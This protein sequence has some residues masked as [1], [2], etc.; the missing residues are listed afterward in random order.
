PYATLFRSPAGSRDLF[1]IS[2]HS[3]IPSDATVT[4]RPSS[5]ALSPKIG[6]A[7]TTTG[8]ANR[9]RETTFV[10]SPPMQLRK[11]GS[12]ST[13]ERGHRETVLDRMR[14]LST[15]VGRRERYEWP[16]CTP[17]RQSAPRLLP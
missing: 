6:W 8:M 1:T 7:R 2:V 10:D 13:S 3:M 4:S 14:C 12:N 5:C 11:C 9:Y 16:R 17:E 15:L